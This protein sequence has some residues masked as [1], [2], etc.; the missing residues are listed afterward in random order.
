[1]RPLLC[2]AVSATLVACT[3]RKTEPTTAPSA[4]PQV[5]TNVATPVDSPPP[6]ARSRIDVF[7]DSVLALMTVEEKAGQ[8]NQIAGAWVQGVPRM[9]QGADTDV[10]AGRIGSFLGIF[11]AEYT[12]EMQRI[13]VT[14]SRLRIPLLLGHDVIHGFRTIFPL[15][16]AEAASWD[17]AAVERAARISAVE[18]TAA[19][20]HWT[21][22]PMVDI[23]RDPRWGRVVEGS[24]E[25]PYLG[26]VMAAARVRGFQGTDLSLP[27][28]MLA[29]AKHYVA[30]GAAEAGRDYNTTD[31]SERVLREVYLPPFHAAVGAGVES[32]M[33]AFNEISGIPMHAHDYLTKDVLRR[34]WGWNGLFVSD[35]TAI[36]EMI[37]HG[38]AAT[39]ADASLAAM[40]A[41]VD[42]DMMS[43]FYL[44]ELPRLVRAGTVAEGDVDTAVRRVLRAKYKLGLFDDP[45]RYSNVE[46][47]RAVTLAPE[48][49]RFAREM[50][51]KSIVLLKNQ[52][53]TLPLRKD[54]RSVALIGVLA[55]TQPVP[56]GTWAAAGRP[57]DVVTIRTALE[58]A[59]EPRT[60][61]R[62][63]RGH[64]ITSMDTSGFRAAIAAARSADAVIVVVGEHHD[65]TGEA[66]SRSTLELP[67]VQL[68]LVKRLHALGKSTVVVL[69]GGRPLSINWI[70]ENVSAI[71]ETWFLGV[72][73]GPA[74]VDV[75]FGD[76]NPSGKLPV[77][78]P[79][80]VG[81]VP[82]YYN[83]KNT[84]RPPDPNNRYTSKYQ[85]VPWTPLYPFG[86]GLSYTTFAYGEP[87]LSAASIRAV[88]TVAVSVTVTNSGTR[89]GEEVVQL[90]IRDDVASVTRPVK[91]LRGFR[92][93]S[94][95]PGASE[96]VTFVLRP[97]DLAFYDREMRRVVEPG[98]FTVFVGGSSADTRQV[99]LTVVP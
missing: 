22:A 8:L 78:F 14:E 77:T 92:K 26:S 66:F 3:A 31:V 96:R 61:V 23:A 21:F 65:M 53:N 97:D 1:M 18:A 84:G 89:A 29:T 24:G 85:D 7:V 32:I 68:D 2:V 59:L 17:V 11:G 46:R 45:Y 13:A 62:Y 44:D 41:G 54:L 40:R 6:V 27:N 69:M 56:L 51:R 83:A 63:A 58:R 5:V 67:G 81:Q 91:E 52:R 12:R 9:P 37:A 90:Y 73:M 33:G 82:I 98:T 35:W 28:T 30:Y 50:A 64:G 38:I 94:L 48:H 72:Q 95:A 34:E 99:K 36:Q 10:R 93:I 43:R 80:T 47:E 19:G 70:D 4:A 76:Y 16:L 57:E 87:A 49:I 86:H 71:L 25:D 55:D 88:D 39:P 79:R 42:M 15:P 60:R 74:V 20:L 75:L